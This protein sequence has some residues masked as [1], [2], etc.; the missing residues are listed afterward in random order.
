MNQIINMIVR[1]LIRR[2]INTGISAGMRKASNMRG[3]KAKSS[4]VPQDPQVAQRAR[5]TAKVS[6]KIT[7]L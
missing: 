3:A 5:Q 4:N 6:R 2:L 1:Q 7:R